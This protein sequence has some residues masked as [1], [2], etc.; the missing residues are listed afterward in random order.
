MCVV[1]EYLKTHTPQKKQIIDRKPSTLEVYYST[2]TT[3]PENPF[4]YMAL[5]I[6]HNLD[7][8]TTTANTPFP[9]TAK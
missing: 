6:S 5:G 7:I 3:P 8:T 9:V 4:L 1:V 2:Q